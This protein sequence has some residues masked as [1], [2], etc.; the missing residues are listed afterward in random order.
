MSLL[1]FEQ[2]MLSF[3]REHKRLLHRLTFIPTDSLQRLCNV[4]YFSKERMVTNKEHPSSILRGTE[5]NQRVFVFIF[6]FQNSTGT[7]KE[8]AD[9]Q[10]V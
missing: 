10:M 7:V 8:N 4:H 6:L 2:K 3:E 9:K 1:L 5:G